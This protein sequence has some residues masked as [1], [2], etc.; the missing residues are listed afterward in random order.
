MLRRLLKKARE[1]AV[2]CRALVIGGID[3]KRHRDQSNDEAKK[4]AAKKLHTFGSIALEYIEAN[5]TNWESKA[6]R[7][8]WRFTMRGENIKNASP[9]FCRAIRSKSVNEITHDAVLAILISI[10]REKT[11]TEE[12]IQGRIETVLDYAAEKCLRDGLNPATMKGNYTA[13]FHI[14]PNL[15]GLSITRRCP[16][17]KCRPLS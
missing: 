14:S 11:E 5:E 12:R 8:Q 3:P 16:S 15:S 4:D 2:E 7:R 6:H 1:V 9:D 17:S 13:H 10:W